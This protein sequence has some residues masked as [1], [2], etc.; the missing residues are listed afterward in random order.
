[1]SVL[2]TKGSF[3][4]Q[5]YSQ[6]FEKQLINIMK[7]LTLVVRKIVDKMHSIFF[8]TNRSASN[9]TLIC[10]SSCQSTCCESFTRSAIKD[11]LAKAS[12]PTAHQIEEAQL[13]AAASVLPKE[14]PSGL[15]VP[16]APTADQIAQARL[17][18][19]VKT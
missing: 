8:T 16:S 12:A 2:S 14:R 11:V 3:P 7:S 4:Q 9:H 10:V 17:D 15:I 19:W 18:E 13:W 5:T 1:M 6:M